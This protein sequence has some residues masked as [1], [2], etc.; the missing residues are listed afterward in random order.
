MRIVAIIFK[1]IPQLAAIV[2]AAESEIKHMNV[3]EKKKEFDL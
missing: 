3:L 2:N 1:Q